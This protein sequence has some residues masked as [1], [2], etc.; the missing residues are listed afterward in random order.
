MK[1]YL[2]VLLACG[3]VAAGARAQYETNT[4]TPAPIPAMPKTNAIVAP[5]DVV[6]YAALNRQEFEFNTQLRL[7]SELE[8][9]HRK[10][11][12]EAGKGEQAAKAKWETDLA[13]ELADK[14]VTVKK[15][16]E[17]A[18]KQRVAFE[19]AHKPLSP[20]LRGLRARMTV[21]GENPEEVA[22]LAKLD[23]RL[24]GVDQELKAAL[25]EGTSYAMEIATNNVPDEIS[26]ISLLL[27]EN[28]GRVRQLQ[29]EQAELEL[30]QLEYR[31]LRRH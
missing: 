18:S 10:R 6:Y 2:I 1:R 14:A 29:K 17:E 9:E 16:L 26:R 8:Q 24:W 4:P 27:Q 15:Q 3:W 21:N 20:A 25:D 19:E 5:E 31:A 30:R 13:Q 11:A 7:L 23:E 28:G 22:F 12:D